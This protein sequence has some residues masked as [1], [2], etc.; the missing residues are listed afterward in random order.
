[1][2]EGSDRARGLDG[3]AEASPDCHALTAAL[4]NREFKNQ[5]NVEDS[6]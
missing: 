5:F 4:N 6:Q 2:F 3:G 1:M